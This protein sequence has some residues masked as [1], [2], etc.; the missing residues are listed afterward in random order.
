MSFDVKLKD[1][2][3]DEQTYSG[4]QQVGIPKSDG[5]GNAW[6]VE[7]P[8][9]SYNVR[10]YEAGTEPTGGF[11]HSGDIAES[12]I[13]DEQVF[14]LKGAISSAG[15]QIYALKT[16]SMGLNGPN[17]PYPEDVSPDGYY[18][19]V[20]VNGDTTVSEIA[21]LFG[22]SSMSKEPIY[23]G[24]YFV[25]FADEQQFQILRVT[26]ANVFPSSSS[27]W[28]NV[29]QPCVL[30]GN[31]AKM[32]YD[33]VLM[34]IDQMRDTITITKNGE[35]RIRTPFGF[36]GIYSATITTDVAASPKLQS[37]SVDISENGTST[38]TPDSGYDGL[39]SVEIVV[40]VPA[41][42]TTEP[43][44]SN[45][46]MADGDQVLIPGTG[47]A[48]SKVIISKPSTMIASNIKNGVDIGGVVGT[49]E[50]AKT[51]E[52]PTVDLD[53][54]SGN[55]TILPL[56][57]GNVMTEVT[58]TKPNTF[59]PSNIRKNVSIGGV[60]GTYEASGGEEQAKTVDLS[61]A[62]GDQVVTPDAGKT[63]SQVTI[64]KPT[65]M[66]PSNIKKDVVI[67]GVTGTLEAGGGGD[68]DAYKAA[69]YQYGDPAG[70]GCAIRTV[71]PASGIR[72]DLWAKASGALS[73]MDENYWVFW[74]KVVAQY[75]NSSTLNSF[76]TDLMTNLTSE[77][78][79]VF[80]GGTKASF[81]DLEHVCTI[82]S[83]ADGDPKTLTGLLSV[84]N[85]SL[86]EL[87]T[88][89]FS[90]EFME[91]G[92]YAF[93]LRGGSG[94]N[95]LSPVA[96]D[97]VSL[98]LIMRPVVADGGT[99]VTGYNV[100]TPS[101]TMATYETGF[102][103]FANAAGGNPLAV[104]YCNT[105]PSYGI[106]NELVAVII[107]ND[108]SNFNVAWYS[109][110]GQTLVNAVLQQFLAGLWTSDMGNVTLTEGWNMTTVQ[111][112]APYTANNL[113]EAI[114]Q[115]QIVSKFPDGIYTEW[116]ST[117]LSE[118]DAY[119]KSIFLPFTTPTYKYVG[120]KSLQLNI[121]LAIPE[122]I[123]N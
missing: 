58:V 110:G 107:A 72:L 122:N 65:T 6:F 63:L 22:W 97:T 51:E 16:N 85:L 109:Y 46:S 50:G 83:I 15:R 21:T 60:V 31:N 38:V 13:G 17:V 103:S 99:R 86:S 62:D 27:L 7:H 76:A 87:T 28:F 81:M 73:V 41:E 95:I 12:Y 88:N 80:E 54:S 89:V 30:T 118:M 35:T 121:T 111:A 47:K 64:T 29:A 45:L 112:G 49:L 2:I 79:S 36:S 37:T 61:M 52:T 71:W 3:G 55:Q 44:T 26:R 20:K 105:I 14:Y 33:N 91:I 39:S 34:S 69:I 74:K 18:Y 10:D 108:A 114:I 106:T 57:D 23:S 116:V 48:Y 96:G 25:V 75:L 113:T 59:I 53:M 5:S 92:D 24:V 93:I 78:A 67:G 4:V 56:V 104:G 115:E 9:I 19:L 66:I 82:P 77:F 68:V 123:T 40:D 43:V 1:K 11:R 84:L 70:D 102:K 119:E 98:P 117:Y 100:K 32:H 120:K 101:G 42:V 90:G 94:G 8:Y